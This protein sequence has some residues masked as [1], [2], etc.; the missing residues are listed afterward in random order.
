MSGS[1]LDGSDRRQFGKL[2]LECLPTATRSTS[3]IDCVTS[4]SQKTAVMACLLEDTRRIDLLL[5]TA[6]RA[7]RE[8][9]G[10][11]YVVGVGSSNN[12][13]METT[14]ALIKRDLRRAALPGAKLVL[15]HSRDA[16]GALLSFARQ[17]GVSRIIVSRAP[18]RP[19]YKSLFSS[20]HS[21]LLRRCEGFQIE[22][23]GFG[24]G[25]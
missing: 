16:A 22:V 25:R 5:E 10:K 4:E 23:V 8:L 21:N 11:L 9:D 1:R 20:P 18:R 17:A 15:L 13:F 7:A 6:M 2:H 24:Y 19:F 3:S 12:S 14:V